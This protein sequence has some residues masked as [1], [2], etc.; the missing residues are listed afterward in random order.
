MICSP[1]CTPR[2]CLLPCCRPACTAALTAELQELARGTLNSLQAAV[3]RT[4]M[5]TASHACTFGGKENSKGAASSAASPAASCALQLMPQC[6]P[7]PPAAAYGHQ[8]I[9]PGHFWVQPM[10]SPLQPHQQNTDGATTPPLAGPTTSSSSNSRGQSGSGVLAMAEASPAT[11]TP[12]SQQ[13]SHAGSC[14]SRAD[15]AVIDNLHIAQRA[16]GEQMCRAVGGKHITASSP[17]KERL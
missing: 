13:A 17:A 4:P 12:L 10:R 11:A 15:S 16:L 7:P 3:A 9:S 5:L 14:Q 8:R 1:W 2:P 6:L